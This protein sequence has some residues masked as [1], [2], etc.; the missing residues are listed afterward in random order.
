MRLFRC[1]AAVTELLPENAAFI[2][3]IFENYNLLFMGIIV[4]A[5]VLNF[6]E[7]VIRTITVQIMQLW[8]NK[9][10]VLVMIIKKI[11]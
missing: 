5:I 2:S 1:F 10:Y 8:Y 4:S 9:Q 6:F 11:I 7:T 3:N